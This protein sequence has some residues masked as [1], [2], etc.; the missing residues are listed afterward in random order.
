MRSNNESPL[1]LSQSGGR[2]E[3]QKIA[4]PTH[5]HHILVSHGKCWTSP[6]PWRNLTAFHW[7]CIFFSLQAEYLHQMNGIQRFVYFTLS[8]MLTDLMLIS[9]VI[10]ISFPSLNFYNINKQFTLR[11]RA[12]A[13]RLIYLVLYARLCKI[14][15]TTTS[16]HYAF[17]RGFVIKEYAERIP[18]G[19][20]NYARDT[21]NHLI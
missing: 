12:K 3:F 9:F 6:A 18:L 2:R 10:Y 4:V 19:P 16:V 20:T 14:F 11:S 8:F 17:I 5:T 7:H 13:G 15:I 1:K 21:C